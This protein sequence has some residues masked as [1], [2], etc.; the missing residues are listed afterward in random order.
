MPTCKLLAAV[1][2]LLLT[3]SA[4]AQEPPANGPDPGVAASPAVVAAPQSAPDPAPKPFRAILTVPLLGTSNAVGV[5]AKDL[6][7]SANQADVHL[8]PDL[9]LRWTQ[10]F[11]Y[12]RVTAGADLSIDQYAVHRD[13]STDSIYGAFKVA[14]TDGHSDLFVPYVVAVPTGDWEPWFKRRDDAL[15][16]LAA[17]V[18]SGFGINAHG[19][20]VRY[21]DATR[22]GDSAVLFDISAGRRLADPV[23]YRATFLTASVDLTYNPTRD[24][25]IGF[26]PGIRL[27]KYD[28]YFGF[29]RRDFRV[30]WVAR[31][32]WTPDWLTRR[33]PHA[34]IDFTL[35]YL[36][37]ASNL[38]AANYTVWEGGP[39]LAMTWRF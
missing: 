34:E 17:G 8:N 2:A 24:L 19:K 7:S 28:S 20:L 4:I 3:G 39:A 22:P 27:R 16:S 36:R 38:K 26:N 33:M 23:D 29:P 35:A 25:L 9:L 31:A 18:S 5:A 12:V 30:G 32:E 14:L 1:V 11:Q 6:A 13:Q 37:N 15:L 21:S 10:Q